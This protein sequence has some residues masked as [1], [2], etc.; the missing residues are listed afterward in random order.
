[1][2]FE[3]IHNKGQARLFNNNFLESLTKSRPWV[4]YSIYIPVCAFSLYYSYKEL[5]FSLSFIAALFFIAIL[6]WTLFEY[7]AHRY[8]FHYEP[9][10]EFGKRIVYIFHG[11]HHEYPRDKTRLFMPPIPSVI[12]ASIIFGMIYGISTL[13]TGTGNF[14]FIY[15]PGFMSGYLLYVSMHYAIHAYSPPSGMK[16]LW[17]NH[18]LHHYK[19]PEKGFGVSNTLWDFIFRTIPAR[20]EDKFKAS[21]NSPSKEPEKSGYKPRKFSKTTNTLRS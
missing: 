11:N 14:A 13:L 6:S 15:F 4:I 18:H 5:N 21:I 9:E 7:I 20:E 3:K 17:R 8:L 10:S 12:F 2:H 19:N 1:M 16:A